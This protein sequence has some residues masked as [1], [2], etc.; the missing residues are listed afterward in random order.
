[1]GI[2]MNMDNAHL[3]EAVAKYRK[4][5]EPR[6][7]KIKLEVRANLEKRTDMLGESVE[8]HSALLEMALDWFIVLHGEED[9]HDLIE[10]AF[11]R[12]V[13]RLKPKLH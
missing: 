1:M 11:R 3:D 5:M 7:A 13:K 6:I 2:H 10:C 4:R 9:A 8:V 12:A